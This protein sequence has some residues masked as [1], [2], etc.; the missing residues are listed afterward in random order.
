M[1]TTNQEHSLLVNTNPLVLELLAQELRAEHFD[2][3]ATGPGEQAFHSLSDWLF[4]RASLP[5]MIDGWILADEYHDNH[6]DLA[7]VLAASQARDSAQGY[8]VHEDPSP[9]AVLYALRG[10]TAQHHASEMP[11][12]AEREEMPLAA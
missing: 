2:V 1:S 11:S 8:I 3:V 10:I 9:A 5:G 6:P 4:S 7:A 12:Q